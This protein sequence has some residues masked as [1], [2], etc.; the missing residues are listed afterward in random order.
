MAENIK[1]SYISEFIF[2]LLDERVKLKIIK[3]N[4]TIQNKLQI[5]IINYKTFSKKY[6]VQDGNG[7]IKIYDA[8]YNQL[9]YKGGYLNGKKNGYGKEYNTS[10]KLIF[11]GEY[12][13]GKPYNGKYKEYDSDILVYEG[14]ISKGKKNGK[15]KEYYSNKKLKFEGEYLNGKKW[16]GK[17][18]N[19]ISYNKYKVSEL[20]EGK[21][22]IEEWSGDRND[23]DRFKGEYLNGERNGKG[24]IYNGKGMLIFEGEFIN[25]EKN[26]KGYEFN[27]CIDN[28]LKFEGEF[29]NGKKWNGK[30]YNKD[31]T[32]FTE[33]INGKGFIKNYDL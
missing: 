5:N 24:K 21:G 6:I 19:Y 31:K 12:F 30:F 25:G 32:K 9:L 15:G 20:K 27:Y 16:N 4:K 26:G 14:K 33:L 10:N 7:K 13:K 1:S 22:L 28:N 18:Y 8:L 17:F 3:N 29:L 2:S 11:I 23:H